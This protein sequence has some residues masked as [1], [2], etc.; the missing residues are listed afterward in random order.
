MFCPSGSI[1]SRRLHKVTF[2]GLNSNFNPLIRNLR[3]AINQSETQKN[4]TDRM[5]TNIKTWKLPE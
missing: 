1:L 5:A 3:R 4:Q 2:S